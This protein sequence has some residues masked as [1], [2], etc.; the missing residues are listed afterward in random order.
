MGILCP[1]GAGRAGRGFRGHAPEGTCCWNPFLGPWGTGRGGVP[2]GGLVPG[3]GRKTTLPWGPGALL[4][5]RELGVTVGLSWDR[6]SGSAVCLVK[7][8]TLS[9]LQISLLLLQN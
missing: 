8:L 9:G 6:I 1:S 5:V 3:G 2:P 4:M 7:F